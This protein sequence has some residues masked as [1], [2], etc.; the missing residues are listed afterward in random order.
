MKEDT[1]VEWREWGAAPFEEADRQGTPLLLSLSATWCTACD[2][3]DEGAYADPKLAAHLTDGFV[4]VRVDVDRQP[5]VR[6]RY[7]MGGFPSTVFAAPDG[8]ILTGAG[9]MSSDALRGALDSVRRTWDAKGAEAGSVPRALQD[10]DPPAGEVTAD[11]E[12]HFVEQVAAAFDEEF[13]GWG[14]DAKFPL[15]RTIEFAAKRDRDRATRTLEAVQTHLYD[16]YDGGFYRYA[17]NRNWG[18]DVHREKLLDENAAL[19]RAFATGYLYTGEESYRDTAEGAIE[20]LTTDLWTG[21]AFAGSQ[22]GGDYFTLDP[23]EREAADAPVVD[24]TV[25]AD[26]NGLTADA[27]FRFGAYTDD[28]DATRYAERA[29]EHVLDTLV[30]DG[31]VT[32]FDA[33]ESEAGLLLDQARVLSGLT[34]GVQATGQY[35][36]AARAVANR[37]LELQAE[38]GAFLDGPAEGPGMLDRPLRPLDTNV[39]LADALL[40]LAALTGDDR[41]RAAAT[42]A[43]AAFAGAYDRMGAQVAAYGAA[44]ARAVYDPLVVE[45]PPAGSRL[46]RAAWRVADHEKVVVPGDRETAVV[47]R[48]GERSAPADSPEEL[49]ER[50]ADASPVEDA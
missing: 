2:E 18:G 42:D 21:E 48:G 17:T 13:G 50:A 39:E 9:F 35:L 34:A 33:P 28:A 37:S 46:H 5:R 8:R 26:R 31:E 40:D 20:Y 4:P 36:D 6:E 44:C 22:A 32:H 14:T 3:M 25:Y 27:L 19:L 24:D 45:T 15:P 43:L 49:M 23:T 16:T 7:N 30:E 11:I 10:P 38:D 12:A 29:V 1:L 47:V 41:Y